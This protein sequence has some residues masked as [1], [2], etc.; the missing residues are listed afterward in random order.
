VNTKFVQILF[1]IDCKW[2]KGPPPAYRVYVDDELF[3]ERTWIW[4]EHYIEEMLQIQAEPGRYTI[5]IEAVQPVGGK[6]KVS[7]FRVES[8][9]AHW[10]DNNLLEITNESS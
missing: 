9:P 3:S 1:N 2:K 6:F 7:D 4:R 10:I 8:G 5:R